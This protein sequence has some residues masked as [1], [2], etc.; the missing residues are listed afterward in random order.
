MPGKVINFEKRCGKGKASGSQEQLRQETK[1]SKIETKYTASQW[2]M[3]MEELEGRKS[4]GYVNYKVSMNKAR[5]IS[6]YSTEEFRTFIEG[7]RKGL[8]DNPRGWICAINLLCSMGMI[9]VIKDSPS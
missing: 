5:I 3:I 8:Y 9:L 4:I 6:G 7:L 1:M 2:K